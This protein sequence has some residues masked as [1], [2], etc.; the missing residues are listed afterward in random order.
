MRIGFDATMAGI[1]GGERG[2]VYQYIAQ[3]LRRM[4]AL[5]PESQFRLLFGLPRA[6]HRETIRAFTAGLGAANVAAVRAPL[7]MHWIRRFSLPVELFVGGLDVFHGPYHLIPRSRA[8]SVLTVHDL[9]FLRD[10]GG[11]YDSADLDDEARARL[12]VRRASLS[13]MTEKIHEAVESAQRVIAV[14]QATADDLIARLGVPAGKIRVVHNG[15]REEVGRVD[16]PARIAAMRARYGLDGAYWLY[17]GTLDPNKNLEVPIEGFAAFRR[18]GGTGVLAL[19]GRSEWYGKVLERLVARLGLE[20]AVRFLGYVPDE[21]LPALYSAATAV[22]M[23]SPLEGFGLPALEAMACGAPVIAADG[24]A[25][26]EVVGDC[27]LLADPDDPADFAAAF[28]RIAEEEAL[29]AALARAGPARAAAFSW[30]RAARQT[31]AVYEELAG[32]ER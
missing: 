14:S 18:S 31:L 3:L 15:V 10:R 17:V 29:R 22:L 7:P 4:P 32:R 11:R 27:G 5:A 20:R 12:A 8:P 26:P 6:R 21:D 2:G 16:D 28:A 23:P 19:A 30:D 24:G 1:A 9:A 13:E 25:L